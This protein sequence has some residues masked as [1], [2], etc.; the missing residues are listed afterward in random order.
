M[1]NKKVIIQTGVIGRDFKLIDYDKM[2]NIF[3]D[4]GIIGKIFGV[5]TIKIFTGEIG[6]SNAS[7]YGEI[8]IGSSRSSGLQPSYDSLRYISEPY[9]VLKHL[10]EHLSERKENLYGGKD[11]VRPVKVVK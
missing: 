7:N 4:V 11:V 9:A 5:G 6:G 2:Q 3:V 8:R 10:Q 1:T